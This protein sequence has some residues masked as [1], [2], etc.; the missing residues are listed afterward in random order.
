MRLEIHGPDHQMTDHIPYFI[1][2]QYRNQDTSEYASEY[3]WLGH[4]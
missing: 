3:E 4:L 2:D 1:A